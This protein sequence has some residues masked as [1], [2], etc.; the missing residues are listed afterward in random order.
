MIRKYVVT[1]ETECECPGAGGRWTL[2]RLLG[3]S[4]ASTF[5]ALA[6]AAGRMLRLR[7]RI[8]RPIGGLRKT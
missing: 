6:I 5:T 2:G 7:L 1:S 4:I 8:A 3:K